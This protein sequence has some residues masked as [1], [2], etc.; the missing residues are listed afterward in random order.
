MAPL[1]AVC[2]CVCVCLRH[3]QLGR[4][5]CSSLED[6]QDERQVRYVLAWRCFVLECFEDHPLSVHFAI[7]TI[8]GWCLGL[9]RWRALTVGAR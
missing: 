7:V 5:S 6:A 4:C 8:A 9:G 3:L 2:V 1:K